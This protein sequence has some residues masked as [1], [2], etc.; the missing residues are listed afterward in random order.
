MIGHNGLQLA[1]SSVEGRSPGRKTA[2]NASE[3]TDRL[4]GNG[5]R[6]VYNA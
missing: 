3:L 6:P 5:H 4:E 1:S 2:H